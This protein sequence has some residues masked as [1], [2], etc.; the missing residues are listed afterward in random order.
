MKKRRQSP[1]AH[2]CTIVLRGL[3]WNYEYGRS[4]Q[5]ALTVYHS[6]FA[7]NS[8][9]K[10]SVIHTNAVLQ[11]CALANDMEALWGIAAKLPIGGKS[12]AD[13]TTFTIIFNAICNNV[14]AEPKEEAKDDDR[15]RRLR[16][17]DVQSQCRRIWGDVV[18]RW[19]NNDLAI[20]ETLVHA[21][22]RT[23]VLSD[24]VLDNHDVL[25]LV[26]QTM[27]I[28]RQIPRADTYGMKKLANV[29]ATRAVDRQGDVP[30]E[31][32]SSLSSVLEQ[33]NDTGM[34]GPEEHESP[35][36]DEFRPLPKSERKLVYAAPS[37][38]TLSLLLQVCLNLKALGPAE[39]YWELLTARDGTY[40]IPPDRENYIRYLRTFRVRRASRL[41]LSILQEVT[42]RLG[43][44]PERKAFR[45]AL[46]ACCRD[47]KNP[48]V[49]ENTQSIIQM[50]STETGVYDIE[51]LADYITVMQNARLSDWKDLKDAMDFVWPTVE[52]LRNDDDSSNA[53]EVMGKRST[54]EENDEVLS[55]CERLQRVW[56]QCLLLAE[57]EVS[58]AEWRSMTDSKNKL[59]GWHQRLREQQMVKD[60][61]KGRRQSDRP[62]RHQ[63]E[64]SRPKFRFNLRMDPGRYK[65]QNDR[66]LDIK[67]PSM[68]KTPGKGMVRYF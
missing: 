62:D 25:D 43:Q 2:T 63:H 4:L 46:S 6:M 35:A 40:R 53:K 7:E 67:V 58:K 52:G 41:S 8:T 9:V 15:Q 16:R 36:G 26:E 19:R 64:S 1:D 37:R 34:E 61:A 24:N 29:D 39:K 21:V 59:S 49:L 42:A 57:S 27:A 56:N 48:N 54:R 50:M 11:V 31:E 45:I 20:D 33:D 60:F 68:R 38:R 5:R 32:S 55:L 12:A 47:T 22:G 51:A 18:E 30:Q 66:R 13:A 23:L 44:T 14:I 65:E 3:A 17:R 10:P 28:P